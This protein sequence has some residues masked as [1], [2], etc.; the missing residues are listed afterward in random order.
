VARPPI[1]PIIDRERD[2]LDRY[3]EA[4]A[5]WGGEWTRV[6]K[7]ISGLPLTEAHEI[8]AARAAE[9]LPHEP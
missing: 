2:R 7:E 5:R 6:S 1:R 4:A 8:V 3:L 9:Y